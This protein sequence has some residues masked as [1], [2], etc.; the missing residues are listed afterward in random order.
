MK[1]IEICGPPCSGKT[2]I[3]DFLIKKFER[4]F[5]S[6]NLLICEKAHLYLNLNFID[7][8]TLFYFKYLKTKK[9]KK[10]KIQR[11]NKKNL[12]KNKKY[13]LNKIKHNLVSNYFLKKYQ[14]ICSQFYD[15]YMIKNPDFTKLINNLLLKIKNKKLRNRN[16]IWIEECIFKYFIAKDINKKNIVVF[17]EGLAQ[18][19]SFLLHTGKSYKKDLKNYIVHKI[20]PDYLIFIDDNINKLLKKTELRRSSKLNSFIYKDEKHISIYKK[21]FK[22]YQNYLK[23]II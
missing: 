15:L 4:K 18:R 21:F 5:I 3:H 11:S 14:N 10:N 16:R 8:I 23:K 6:S 17:D 9:F 1:I 22:E 7:K 20:K 13:I 12:S 19:S 2:Y